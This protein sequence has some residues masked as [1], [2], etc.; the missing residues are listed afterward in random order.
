MQHDTFL[1]VTVLVGT[2]FW[3][4]CPSQADEQFDAW[5]QNS[6]GELTREELPERLRGNFDRV[7]RNRDGVISLV[8]H[9]AFTSRNRS[10]PASNVSLPASVV[11]KPDLPYAETDHPRQTLDLFLPRSPRKGIVAADRIQ[12]MEEVG[13]TVTS[14]ADGRTWSRTSRP[15]G[16]SRRQSIID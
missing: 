5:D 16:I 3:V 11:L 9:V 2:C 1:K 10:A 4:S 6:N 13:V 12:F 8:E 14:L 7:D 15:D